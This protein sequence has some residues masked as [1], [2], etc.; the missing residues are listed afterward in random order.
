[1]P[2]EDRFYYR[3]VYGGR[4]IVYD[5]SGTCGANHLAYADCSEEW[6]AKVIVYE[7]N[8]GL[9]YRPDISYDDY[10]KLKNEGVL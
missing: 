4:S 2:K 1:M 6:R 5:R 8:Q 10:V 3:N 9:P 7:M